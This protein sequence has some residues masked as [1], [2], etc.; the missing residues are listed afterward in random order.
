VCIHGHFSGDQVEDFEMRHRLVRFEEDIQ[1]GADVGEELTEIEYTSE[2]D[3]NN[4][5]VDPGIVEARETATFGEEVDNSGVE[6]LGIA[7]D[8]SLQDITHSQ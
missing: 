2:T 5:V 8:N 6:S 1:Q 7:V 3:G 4:M